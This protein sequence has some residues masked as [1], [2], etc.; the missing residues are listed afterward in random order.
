MP[1]PLRGKG[2][3]VRNKGEGNLP[4]G[5]AKESKILTLKGKDQ[6]SLAKITLSSPVTFVTCTRTRTPK[7]G[8]EGGK[9]GGKVG[10]DHRR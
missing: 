8:K 6:G 7:G 10:G 5:K 9:K 2:H 4:Y 1:I 3:E